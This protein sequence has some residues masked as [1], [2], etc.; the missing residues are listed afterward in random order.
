M[1]GDR[2]TDSRER[3]EQSREQHDSAE[4]VR[5]LPGG[6][7]GRNQQRSHEHDADGL[8]PDDDCRDRERGEEQVERADREA[9]ARGVVRVEAQQ[10]ELLPERDEDRERSR[11]EDAN[12]AEVLFEELGRLTEQVAIQ[13]MARGSGHVPLDVRHQHEAEAEEDGERPTERGIERDPRT[14]LDEADDH[15]G[16]PA[17]DRAAEDEINGFA[18]TEQERTAEPRQ[19]RV[20]NHV[21]LQTLPPEYRKRTDRPGHE[22]EARRARR[23]RP[24]GRR[25]QILQNVQGAPPGGTFN[26]P[27]C[28][29]ISGSH[30][31]ASSTGST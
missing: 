9:E 17:R 11:S 2:S 27:N 29:R 24:Q 25:V 21:A 28:L 1:A 14:A 31:S 19:G 23:N 15:H 30:D 10:L 4:P 6:R 7:S 3:A 26:S 20:R 8:Q 12:H 16:E 22:P 18:G 5:P 13:W